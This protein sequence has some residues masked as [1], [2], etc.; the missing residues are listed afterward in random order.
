MIP[1][2]RK[3]SRSVRWSLGLL[4]AVHTEC[5]PMNGNNREG[6]WGGEDAVRGTDEGISLWTLLGFMDLCTH[7]PR[8]LPLNFAHPTGLLPPHSEASGCHSPTLQL[9]GTQGPQEVHAAGGKREAE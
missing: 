5:N 1:C 6:A 3:L 2:F 9:S 4:G 8:Y 7:Q